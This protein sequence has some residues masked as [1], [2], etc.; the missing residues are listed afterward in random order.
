M[1]APAP[2]RRGV[3][4]RIADVFPWRAVVAPWLVSRAIS[5]TVLLAAMNDPF[6]GSRVQQLA[7]KWDGQFYVEIARG[8]YGAV[9]VL[10]PRWPF[11]PGLPLVIRLLGRIGSDTTLILVL[12][13]IVF[14][15]ALAGVYRIARG[16]C[17]A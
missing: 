8:G 10:F 3:A 12:N 11:F 2:A 9:D 13:Q 6:G 1:T 17:V 5:L 4:A 14:L 7:I 16:H 15:V